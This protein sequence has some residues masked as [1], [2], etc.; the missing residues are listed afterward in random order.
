[1]DSKFGIFLD[2]PILTKHVRARLRPGLLLPWAVVALAVCLCV[3]Y[4]GYVA[5]ALT[6]PGPLTILLGIQLVVLVFMGSSQ[7]ATS[8]GSARESGILD[9]HRVSPTPPLVNVVGFLI[10]GP[11]REYVLFGITLPFVLL[12]GS[13]SILGLAGTLASMLGVLL[14]AWAFHAV[15]LVGALSSKKP[16]G[17]GRGIVAIVLGS[18]FGLNFVLGFGMAGGALTRIGTGE[19][20]FFGLRM[21][22]LL[23]AVL[24]EVPL[25]G[26]LIV[27][28]VRK[29]RSEREQLFTKRQALACMLTVAFLLL[30][31]SW[32][33]RGQASTTIVLLYILVGF[34]V[35]LG[36]TFTPN[37]STY[38]RGVRRALHAGQ[39]RPSP[40]SDA[41]VNRLGVGLLGAIVLG[42]ATIAWEA[43]EG[44]VA[45]AGNYSLSIAV[46]V[47]VV[48][49]MGFGYQAAVLSFPKRGVSYFVLFLFFVWF[50]P[51]FLGAILLSSGLDESRA[52]AV[53]G[54]SPLAG[55]LL[56]SG[57][58][59]EAADAL[60]AARVSAIAPAVSFLVLFYLRLDQVQRRLD[61][62]VRASLPPAKALDP[63]SQP[64]DLVKS[65]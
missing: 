31:L 16:K 14:G 25:L 17:G 24:A 5:N 59:R 4:G 21:P 45:G 15:S 10:G 44:R 41:G 1:M 7:I 12:I 11:I 50:L 53:F 29:M 57:L 65:V 46:G 9:F 34:G 40:W 47:L 51:L 33:F 37:Q 49:Y 62:Q 43:I 18:Y 54:I 48:L 36:A 60:N 3:T 27:P 32:T 35:V 8:V 42:A 26:F 6:G 52:Y 20:S 22:W 64:E 61:R 63:W 38:L 23:F 13:M 55:I 19:V 2:N 39:R 58:T 28:A 30:G 56:S